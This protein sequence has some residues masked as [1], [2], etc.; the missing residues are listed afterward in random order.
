VEL[1]QP[2]ATGRQGEAPE[3]GSQ[4]V[5]SP[6][7]EVL[8]AEFGPDIVGVEAAEA[9]KQLRLKVRAERLPDICHYLRRHPEWRYEYLADLTAVECSDRFEMVYRLFSLQTGEYAQI[10]VELDPEKPT[11]PSLTPSWP[12]ANW[13]EREVF[14]LFGVDFQGHPDQRRIMLPEDWVGHPLRKPKKAEKA[15]AG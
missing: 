15:D 6:R 9:G 7:A 10:I 2:A 14:D 13:L 4:T 1:Q 8:R 3:A 12:A 11:V 5:A